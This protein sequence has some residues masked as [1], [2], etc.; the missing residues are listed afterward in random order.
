[1]ADTFQEK[2][3]S[4]FFN[5]LSEAESI[6]V[7]ELVPSTQT[8]ILASVDDAIKNFDQGE[9]NAAIRSFLVT[10][11]NPEPEK[12]IS[13][14]STPEKNDSIEQIIEKAELLIKNEDYL[15]A[16]NLYSFV[17]RQDIK[18]QFGLKGLGLCLFNLGDI[19]AAKKCF[20]ALVEI[21]QNP[22][23]YALL[24]ISF[25]KEN[26]DSAA[27]ENFSKVK[28]ASKLAP[29]LKFNFFKEYG[30]SLTRT[31]RFSEASD[32]YLQ[33]LSLNPRSHTILINLGTLEIQRKR[34]E[35]ATKYFQQ[36][37]DF[38]PTAA[39]AFCGIGI[40]A[41]MTQEIEIARLYFEKTLEV[42]CQNS[43]ALH[44]LHSLAENNTDWRNL[45]VR[46]VQALI[47]DPSNLDLR[48]LLATTLLKQNDWAGCE[49]ELNLIVNRCPGYEKART[50]REE[51]SLHKHRQGV[52]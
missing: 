6:Q 50:L 2:I 11:K 27:Q 28:D 47:K 44:Q 37:L 1:M 3:S 25:L 7:R 40:V 22:E 12:Q 35:K 43:V 31:E 13:P 26:N 38:C 46:L 39:K 51:L 15:L 30:N 16:R 45:K 18:N 4:P 10:I 23:G 9:P 29:D 36:A 48:F 24:G 5:V 49:G 52:T 41:Q 20:K 17:L 14:I 33:A 21:H 32:Y 19:N 8:S 42:D 34:Y